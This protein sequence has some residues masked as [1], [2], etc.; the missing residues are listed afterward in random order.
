MKSLEHK[1]KFLKIFHGSFN[2]S[3]SKKYNVEIVHENGTKVNC[4]DNDP[5][6]C[7]GWCGVCDPKAEKGQPGFCHPNFQDENDDLNEATETKP[8]KNWGWCSKSCLLR[9][10]SNGAMTNKLQVAFVNILA[11]ID[12][13]G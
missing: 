2:H 5:D 9:Q 6:Q 1:F 7:Y 12:C 3:L 10:V 11:K 4:F 13:V 8:D